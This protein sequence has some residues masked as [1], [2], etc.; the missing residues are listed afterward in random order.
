[1][2]RS[3]PDQAIC[4]PKNSFAV[5]TLNV[6]QLALDYSSGG[7]LFPPSKTPSVLEKELIPITKAIQQNGGSGLN[8]TADVLAFMYQEGDAAFIG[9]AFS[10]NDSA[11]CGKL[12][13]EQ[14]T[15]EFPVHAFSAS[16]KNL[17]QYDTTSGIIG[18][19]ES[20]LLLLYPFSNHDAQKTAEAC[21]EL[22][23]QKKENSILSDENFCAEQFH[24]FD[25]SL[26][27]HTSPLLTF[28][29]G[30]FIVKTLFDDIDYVS[31]DINFSKGEIDARKIVTSNGKT[32]SIPYN[33]S[34]LISCDPK[35]VNG[36]L[37][38]PLDLQNKDLISSY[39]NLPPVV[40]LPF[41]DEQ[42]GKLL[43]TFN[44]NCSILFH[45]TMSYDFNYVTY[46]YDE[47]FNSKP[48][49]AKLKIKTMS[50]SICY[51]LK[52]ENEARK[53][54]S[55]FAKQD[56]LEQTKSGWT[57]LD[58]GIKTNFFIEDHILTMTTFPESDG[59]KRT[60]PDQWMGRDLL[61]P[62][63]EYV[64]HAENSTL[65]IFL[66][67]L[68]NSKKIIGENLDVMTISQPLI[69]GKTRS[70]NI[71]LKLANK[72]VNG[73]IQL[74]ELSEKIMDGN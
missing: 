64:N 27:M 38:I 48:K 40:Y 8:Q 61:F 20:C 42:A 17:F 44:G 58:N 24:S 22:L 14:L 4:I 12:I 35:D 66:S 29:N 18:M 60:V 55:E 23:T 49:T 65:N 1:M 37:R 73:L 72:D 59:K 57:F 6:R 39:M 3:V 41:D 68:S 45:D 62:F 30:G 16:R 54:F 13:R 10:L 19:N 69:D 32:N 9:I 71:Y 51:G 7:H 31:Y 2:K 26:W 70:S 63:G 43:S 34:L 74:M 52:D 46:E 47:N 67:E 21:T 11:K 36:F 33:D 15:K 53:L 5:L 28:T 56:S 50:T 25:V